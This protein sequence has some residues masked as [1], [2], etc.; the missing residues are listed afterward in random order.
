MKYIS[1]TALLLIVTFLTFSCSQEDTS[2][3]NAEVKA[4]T[5]TIAKLIDGFDKTFKYSQN[6]GKKADELALSN[7]FIQTTE[8]D[9]LEIFKSSTSA[10]SSKIQYSEEFENFSLLITDAKSFSSKEDY[11]ENLSET[12]LLVNSSQLS[13]DEKQILVNKIAFMNAFV[14]WTDTLTVSESNKSNFMVKSDCDGWWSCWGACVAGTVGSAVMGAGT[15]GLAGAAV[16]TVVLPVVGT[17]SAGAVGAIV[18]G[19]GGALTGAATF[20]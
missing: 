16:G 3:T 13:T 14:N 19:I 7:Y 6:E 17:V 11:L 10:K 9:G 2:L 4:D 5:E 1:K 20:C 18:G 8:A 12:N 15:L